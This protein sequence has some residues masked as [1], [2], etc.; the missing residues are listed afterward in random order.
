MTH[1]AAEGLRLLAVNN[2]WRA[3]LREGVD[4][5][6]SPFV[7]VYAKKDA[8]SHLL[9]VTWHTRMTGTYRLF[10]CIYGRRT[11]S[12]KRAREILYT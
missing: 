8:D 5:G 9:M 3:E 1:P 7:T 2:G 11:V 10:S 6:S 12:L 4:S